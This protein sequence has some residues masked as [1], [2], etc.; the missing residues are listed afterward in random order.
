MS[1]FTSVGHDDD[2]AVMH[3]FR[4][5]SHRDHH[6]LELDGG[7]LVDSWESP[8]RADIVDA[9]CDAAGFASTTVET[10]LVFDRALAEQVHDPDYV[11]FLEGAHRRWVD[12]GNDT[13]CAMAFGWPARRFRDVVPK[14]LEAQLG[15]YSFAAD[16][17]ISANTWEAITG[18]ASAA[19]AA[20]D[21]I[22]NT[23][24]STEAAP[25]AFARCRPPGHHA[26][27]DQFGG[28][29]YLNNSALAAQ[30][31][32][33]NGA[34]RV[35]VVDVDYHHG[36]GTQDVFYHR[37]DVLHASI[38]GDPAEEFPYFLGYADE[39]GEQAGEGCNRNVPLARGTEA[40]DWFDALDSTLTWASSGGDNGPPP[41]ALVV[42]LGLD[43]YVDDPISHFRLRSEHYL[44]LGQR[45]AEVGLPTVLVLEGGYATEALGT[46]VVNVLTG[47]SGG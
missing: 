3:I 33:N 47:Y 44:E 29:C 25:V 45:L 20:A 10:R 24:V 28:Y 38:H 21:H 1:D 36:N 6:V 46:N 15:Y 34:G 12:E 32:R 27:R 41:D 26:S 42:P 2:T 35:A 31:L 9:A 39:T 14:T 43:T 30:R 23:G 7:R 40:T 19:I 13:P 8:D 22:S 16:C 5:V 37:F 4:S 18:S 11:A 17:S